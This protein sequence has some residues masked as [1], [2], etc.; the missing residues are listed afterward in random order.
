M[1]GVPTAHPRHPKLYNQNQF[2]IPRDLSVFKDFIPTT[3]KIQ[4]LKFF[5]FK[6]KFYNSAYLVMEEE[7]LSI[8][9]TSHS[10]HP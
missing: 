6:I 1:E 8:H 5:I 9:R 7:K 4:V 2:L 3:G 10:V